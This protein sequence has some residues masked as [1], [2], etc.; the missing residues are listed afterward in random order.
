VRHGFLPKA[1]LEDLSKRGQMP[2]Y[3]IHGVASFYSS[4]HLMPPPKAKFA[5]VRHEFAI[6][7]APANCAPILSAAR[8]SAPEDVQI[9]DVSCLGRCDH[10][11]SVSSTIIFS[12]IHRR[13]RRTKLLGGA[14]RGENS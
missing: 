9:R 2:L 7:T 4:F 3:Q 13:A 12:R 11:P 8:P 6:S 5:S 1:E 10:A 14:I